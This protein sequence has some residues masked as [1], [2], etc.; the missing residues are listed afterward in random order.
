MGAI[1]GEQHFVFS[2]EGAGG[3]YVNTCWEN[4]IG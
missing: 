3:A 1:E 4:L 2:I